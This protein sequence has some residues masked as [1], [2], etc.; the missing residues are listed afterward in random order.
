MHILEQPAEAPIQEIQDKSKISSYRCSVAKLRSAPGMR[1]RAP[2]VW[3]L[4]VQAG[5]DPVTGKHRQVSRVFRGNLRDAKKARAGLIVEVSK[6][7][8]SGSR[9]T[10]DDLFADWIVEL[11]RKGRSPNTVDG[12]EKV[13]RRN[14]QPTFG[15]KQVTKVT[16]KSLTDLY[17]AHQSRGLAP[18]SVYQIHACLSS[19]FTQACRWGWRESNPAQWAEP[20]AIPN[21]AP[22]VPTPEEVRALIDAAE[23]SK[24]PE[25]ARAILVAATTGL[26]R[27]E[28]CGL[29]VRDVDLEHGVLDVSGSVTVLKGRVIKEIPTKNRRVRTIAIDE[30]TMGILRAQIEMVRERAHLVRVAVVADAFVFSDS[31]DGSQPWKPDAISRF[32]ARLR[33]RIDLD[34]LDFHYLRKFMETYGQEMG[35]SVSQVAMR[36]GHDP[37]IAAKHYSGRVTETDR[38][39]ATAIASLLR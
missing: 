36:A 37:A 13:Y 34:H 15:T 22:V 30:L 29:R 11:Q 23:Q 33:K 14:I 31:P 25:Y 2:D 8:H 7:R 35:F 3:E 32:F 6:G 39:L 17:G 16:T 12:Y 27:A 1:E 26:R 28:L 19:M 4:V 24:R 20:P 18:R 38:A 9:A 21:V 5:R 10:V